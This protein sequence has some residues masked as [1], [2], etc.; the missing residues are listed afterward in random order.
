MQVGLGEA[1]LRQNKLQT[2]ISNGLANQ[3]QRDEYKL[4]ADALNEIKLDLGFDCNDDGIPDT[5]EIFHQTAKT[6]CC[7]FVFPEREAR[8]LRQTA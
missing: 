6:S 7:R 4:L 5:I 1:I 2:L 8:N 3:E